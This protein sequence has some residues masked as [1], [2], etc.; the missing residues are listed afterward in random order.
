MATRGEERLKSA[1][2]SSDVHTLLCGCGKS[3]RVRCGLCRVERPPSCILSCVS[4]VYA[5]ERS[6]AGKNLLH[7]THHSSQ[8]IQERKSLSLSAEAVRPVP[9]L[10]RRSDGRIA[11]GW[12]LGTAGECPENEKTSQ[13]KTT[14][15]EGQARVWCG[16]T[17]EGTAP[18]SNLATAPAARRPPSK[19][20]LRT[21]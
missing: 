9:V 19:H 14:E 17:R 1:R 21:D 15:K 20:L 10:S 2:G 4:G 13:D 18:R 16:A 7:S 11:D 5:F 3:G 8:K 12:M 6:V